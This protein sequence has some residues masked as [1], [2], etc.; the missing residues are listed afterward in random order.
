MNGQNL[1]FF[2]LPPLIGAVIGLFTNWLAIKMLFRPLKAYTL[3]GLRVPFTPGILPR[4]RSGIAQSLGA[5]VAEDLLTR[6]AVEARLSS[7]GFKAALEGALA[8]GGARALE[9]KAGGLGRGLSPEMAA[10]LKESASR[11]LASLA[12]SEPFKAGADAA[13]K[14]IVRELGPL[15]LSE[16]AG[17]DAGAAFKER[18][19]DPA[20]KDAL[21]RLAC[22][23]IYNCVRSALASGAGF[24]A[25][26]SRAAVEDIIRLSAKAAYPALAKG[27]SELM[28]DATVK[29]SLER[30]GAKLIRKTLD[31]FNAVQRFFIGL[32]QYDKAILDN[33]PATIA[34]FSEAMNGL[35]GDE[36]TKAALIDR[37]A[38]L[39]G[40][41]LDRPLHS[42]GA[43][44]SDEAVA[45]SRERLFLSLR[46]ALDKQRPADAPGLIKVALGGLRVEQVLEALPGIQSAL[47]ASTADWLASL[48]AHREERSGAA[49]ALSGVI[50]GFAGAFS[51]RAQAYS[52]G[53]LSGLDDESLFRLARASSAGLAELAARESGA[54]LASLDVRSL[55]VEKIDS[56]QMIEVERMLL[57]VIDRELRAV[58]WFGGILGFLIGIM[59]SIVFLFR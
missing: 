15:R 46:T 41:A 21:A 8:Q 55:V 18:F 33:M 40:A 2:F 58:T 52:L 4:E 1:L 39:L 37:L 16:L 42:Y 29:A 44:S 54:L 5:T 35:L 26:I 49:K 53:E 9:L 28:A 57:R 24:S 38:V 48:L 43:F 19:E 56:L 11:A 3:L 13:V 32:G 27:L 31:R 45:A 34:D 22:D 14:L 59:Q 30:I 25:F 50:K 6:D 23:A 51:E 47:S 10:A 7:P 36:K 17:T 20:F 12:A